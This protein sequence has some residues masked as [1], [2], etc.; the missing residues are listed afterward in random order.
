MNILFFPKAGKWLKQPKMSGLLKQIQY[1]N[2]M[3]EKVKKYFHYTENRNRQSEAAN[4]A[5]VYKL[6][7]QN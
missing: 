2:K 3:A 7:G 1:C 6:A 5:V 4:S